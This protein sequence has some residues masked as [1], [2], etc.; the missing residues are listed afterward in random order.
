MIHTEAARAGLA[1]VLAGVQYAAASALVAGMHAAEVSAKST[2]LFKDRTG[3]TRSS[4]K[5]L[6]G[7]NRGFVSAGGASTF[8]QYGT[9][10]HRIVAN[11]KALRFV[12]GGSTM[13]RKSVN[14]PGTAPRPFM[15]EA[16]DLGE[17]AAVV[18][19]EDYVARA[20][21]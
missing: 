6:V 17:I 15:T 16:R 19:A 2:A 9:R 14:H 1:H 5:A 7:I 18:A 13:F 8:L 11:G 21:A 12:I 4:I 3:D 10:A 20:V